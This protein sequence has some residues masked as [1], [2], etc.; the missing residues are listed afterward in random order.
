[1]RTWLIALV[2]I[3]ALLQMPGEV[4]AVD[5][6]F[7]DVD[8]NGL[9]NAGDVIVPDSAWVGGSPFVSNH[10]FVVPVGCNKTLVTVPMPLQGVM[11]TATK[12]TFHG[13]F[14]MLP[15]GGKG[16][17]LIADPT[18]VPAPGL[19]NGDLIVGNGFTLALIKSGG[20]N[21]L[22]LTEVAVARKAVALVGTG[23][24][25]FKLAEV[26][27]NSP[28]QDT[29][30]GIRCTG[31]LSFESTTVIGSRMNIQ[32]LA[33]SVNASGSSVAGGFS[34]ADLCDNPGSNL[35]GNGNNNDLIDAGDYPCTLNLAGFTNVKFSSVNAMLAACQIDPAVG[36]NVFHALNDPLIM[37]AG[38]GAGNVLDVRGASIVGRY[39]VTLAAE[40]GN[41]LTQGAIIDHGEQLGLVSPGGAR[42]WVFAD[43]NSIDRT[44]VDREDFFGPSLGVT[45]VTGTCFRSPNPVN[46]GQDG[47]GAIN[48]VGAVAPA[49]CL[50]NPPDFVPVLNGNF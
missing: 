29:R 19:G 46:V 38:A 22:P 21:G 41:V 15:P 14:D 25:T 16:I 47:V 6:A 44:I 2:A 50:Q 34:L 33:G 5:C 37:I 45:N 9:F 28:I 49:P 1:M 20:F 12:I 31:D 32:S 13:K 8:D 24:C 48:L 27:G 36:N 23:T 4:L 3:I 42:I 10:P 30:I 40:D 39:R 17:V 35:D 26:R 43:P 11:V 7:Q 18:K